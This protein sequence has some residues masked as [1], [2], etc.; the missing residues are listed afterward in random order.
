MARPRS[1]L[2]PSA[3]IFYGLG[4]SIDL[5]GV[6]LYFSV[7]YAV[8]NLYLQVPALLVGI[9][10]MVIRGVD[11]ISDPLFGWISDNMRSS[12]GRRRPFI[13]VAGVLSGL[14]LPCLFLVSP[15]WV[16]ITFLEASVI[17]WYMIASSLI[18]I[19][20]VSMF[21]MPYH[22]L[23]N[24]L[25]PDYD[26]RSSLMSYKGAMQKVFE[27]A[28]FYALK[29][30]NLG[31]F[32]I[33][34]TEEKNTLLGIQVFTSILGCLMAICAILIFFNV[35]ERYYDYVVRS[36]QTRVRLAES[37]YETM[38]CRPFRIVLGAS[39]AFQIGTSMVGGLGYYT[40]IYHVSGGD[41]IVGDDWNFWMGISFMIGGFLGAIMMGRFARM[42]EKRTAYS[43]AL[44]IGMLAYG[45]SWFLY[46]P[47][48]PWL[49]VFASGC[50]A[51]A[52]GGLWTVHSSMIADIIDYD[53]LQT[54]KRRE[55]AFSASSSW[56]LKVGNALGYFTFALI[57]NWAQFDPS[58]NVQSRE[59]LLAIRG[60]LVV[61]PLIGLG[62]SFVVL[63]RFSVSKRD[64]VDIRARLEERRGT[65]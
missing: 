54:G 44:L 3:K 29:F 41:K 23:G 42:T 47:A 49:Q 16:E 57:L 38:R 35:K 9:A 63:S 31:W 65:I 19:P 7:A 60:A 13:L 6:W 14:G 55:G 46:N 58:V 62:I 1:D 5:W 37:I 36:K 48:F 18:Y 39:L 20:I 4:T 10:L 43:V 32:L 24:E 59:T 50:M 61:I 33:P 34:G 11:A 26:E 27:I 25:T 12:F 40:T 64:F 21:S 53:E 30:T 52:A 8:F 17:F 51:F 28:N 56:I 15:E 2:S 22:S 45:S